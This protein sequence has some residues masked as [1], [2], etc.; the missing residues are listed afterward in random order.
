MKELIIY[1]LDKLNEKQLY[2]IYNLVIYMAN[3]NLW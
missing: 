1:F 2:R 3:K